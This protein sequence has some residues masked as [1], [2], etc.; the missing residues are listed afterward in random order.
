MVRVIALPAFLVL[1]SPQRFAH[2]LEKQLAVLSERRKLDQRE[3]AMRR[4]SMEFCR[5]A[6]WLSNE[7]KRLKDQVRRL[8]RTGCENAARLEELRRVITSQQN[9]L[10]AERKEKGEMAKHL[11][12]A[13]KEIETLK[14][15]E[16]RSDAFV[17]SL[18]RSTYASR[19][20]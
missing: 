14:A 6:Q 9:A 18:C 2:D 1:T 12:G 19:C 8:T 17:A 13:L 4:L 7:A 3:R 16:A 15:A 11:A 10:E 5:E 20:A